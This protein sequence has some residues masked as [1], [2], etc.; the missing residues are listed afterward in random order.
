[1][2]WTFWAG[3]VGIALLWGGTQWFVSWHR[4]FERERARARGVDVGHVSE[5]SAPDAA[6]AGAESGPADP[7]VGATAGAARTESADGF[8]PSLRRR[9]RSLLGR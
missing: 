7:T 5:A 8:A 3:L 4:R 2:D 6:E 9:I 1:M